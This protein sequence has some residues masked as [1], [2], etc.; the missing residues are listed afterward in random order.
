MEV[1]TMA[2]KAESAPRSERVALTL[3]PPRPN[4]DPNLIIGLNGKIYVIPKGE[5]SMVPQEVADEYYRSRRALNTQY[6]N[7]KVKAD[8]AAEEARNLL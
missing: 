8:R 6:V 3:D 7:A 1:I 2:T 5:T 4:E